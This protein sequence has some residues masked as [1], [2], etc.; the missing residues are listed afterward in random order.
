MNKGI[1]IIVIDDDEGLI[2]AIK[3]SFEDKYYIEGFTSSKE[4]IKKLQKKKFDILLLDYYVDEMNGKEI[5]NEIRKTNKDLYIVLITG[6][7]EEIT[8][9]ES[10]ENLNIQNYFEKSGDFKKLITFIEGVIKSIDFFN[11]KSCTTAERLKKLRKIN[12]LTQ[13]DIAKYLGINRTAVSQ[14]ESGEILPS[15]QNIIK[16]AKLYNVTTDYI[17]CYELD[18]EKK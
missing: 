15:T 11:N 13:D 9:T 6:Y 14:Y 8:G 1:K 12:N 16:L 7:G 2:E 18:V 5:V 10:L 17:L 4:A 3:D